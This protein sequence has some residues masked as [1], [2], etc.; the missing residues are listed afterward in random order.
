MKLKCFFSGMVGAILV[1]VCVMLILPF[2][3]D[4]RDRAVTSELLVS[5]TPIKIEINDLLIK[6]EEINIDLSK[7]E[8]SPKLKTI[9]IQKTGVITVQGGDAGQIFILTPS[10]KLDSIDWHCQGG[11]YDA[12]PSMCRNT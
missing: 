8:L 10:K 7:Y 4:Y 5:I 9:T 1:L 6:N 12:M 3:S 11:N 2:Y